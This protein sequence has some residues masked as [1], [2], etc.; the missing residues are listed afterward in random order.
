MPMQMD[1]EIFTSAPFSS[2]LLILNAIVMQPV[3]FAKKVD[4]I[5]IMKTKY[6]MRSSKAG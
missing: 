5:Q 4:G 3:T 2:I 6:E 1:D